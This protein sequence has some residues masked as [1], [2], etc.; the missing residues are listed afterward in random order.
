MVNFDNKVQ[1][2]EWI[3]VLLI[4][5]IFICLLYHKVIKEPNQFLVPNGDG[6][7]NYYTFMYHIKYDSSL[8]TF[9]GMNYPFGEN[10]IFTDNQP[11]LSNTTKI[12]STILPF[13]Q[14]YLPAVHNL[15]LILGIIFGGLGLFLCFRYLKVDFYFSV[16]C[17]LGI[18]ALNPQA[19]RINAHFAMFYPIIPWIFY[20]WL[21][22]WEGNKNLLISA[23]IGLVITLSG[24]LHMYYFITGS[25]LTCLSIF[26]YYI[27]KSPN[28][29]WLEMIKVTLLQVIIPFTILTFLSSFFNHSS[30]RPTEPWGFFL[31]HSTWEG[32]FFS[33]KL[34]LFEFVNNN[35]TKVRIL[36]GEGKNYIGIAAV[37]VSLF[38][39]L[40]LFF[41]FKKFKI[42]IG[43][44]NITSYLLGI[45]ILS[46]LISF[47]YPFTIS[48]LEWLLDYTGP[49]KQFRSIGRVGWVSF[50]A[51]N[52]IS[53]PLIYHWLKNKNVHQ[54]Y[55]YT[56]PFIIL[57]EGVL[58][59]NKRESYQTNLEAYQCATKQDLPINA[60]DYQATLPDP[61]FH[62]GSE[63][64]SWW[65]QAENVNQTFKLG[66]T[67]H[68]PT[69]GVNMSR[70]SFKQSLLLNELI[71]QPTKVP[72]IIEIIRKKST[73]PI[74][75]IESKLQI[76]D[77]RAKLTHWTKYAPIVFE[78]DE[79]LLR[80]LELEMFE[81][82]VKIYN[83]SIRQMVTV[84][85]PFKKN[86]EFT[87]IKGS[88]GW[89]Y[90]SSIQ[91]DSIISGKYIISYTMECPNP[92][93]VLSTTEAYQFDNIHGTLDYV[94]EG[95]RFNYKKIEGQKLLFETPV[96]LKSNVA[97][98]VVKVSKFNQKEKDILQ[99][100]NAHIRTAL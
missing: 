54:L 77:S 21:H 25:I 19:A 64:F 1:K 51:I 72:E 61:Y 97:K 23:L 63:S 81:Q 46:A 57:L 96:N 100:S 44:A 43:S 6:M 8:M 50:Y 16:I 22:F 94:G 27:F 31:F 86:L 68:L 32:L 73:K 26:L 35:I 90:E 76:N 69:M 75:V 74:L 99:I 59:S 33:Y 52:L 65:D 89:G 62:I 2:K 15:S 93:F 82:V 30:D 17:T 87:K 40:Q 4:T 18:I 7:K 24:L 9:E 20:L 34:P 98:L 88:N 55:F 12:I 10:I 47:G 95:N 48:G 39:I 91:F 67:L 71:D 84:P 41:N 49:F 45:F 78:N 80:R 70:T 79:F 3:W 83:D 36:D 14:C 92:T 53:V 11:L 28:G 13:F 37:L 38:G 5:T 56:I 60:N 42:F 85:P 66:Y 58:F 29:K